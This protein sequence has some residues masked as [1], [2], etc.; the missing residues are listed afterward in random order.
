MAASIIHRFD[1]NPLFVL[2]KFIFLKTSKRPS[3]E[4]FSSF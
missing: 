2:K 1:V 3:V 4:F